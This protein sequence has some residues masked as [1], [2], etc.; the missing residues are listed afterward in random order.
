MNNKNPF[1]IDG[2]TILVTG[3]SSGIGRTI[4][5]E[6][7]SLGANVVITGRNEQRL[8]ETLVLLKGDGHSLIVANLLD[9]LDIDLIVSKL[10]VLDGIVNCA[11]L[12][13]LSPFTFVT[14]EVLSDVFEINFFAPVELIRLLIKKKRF[15][16]NASIVF[17]SSISGV[18]CSAI[19]SSAYSAS[20]GAI[21]GV[22]KGMALDLAS[23]GIRVNCVNPGVINTDF[24]ENTGVTAEDLENDIKRYPLGR[25]GCTEDVAYAAIYL[26]SDASSWVTGTNLLI[27]G[28]YTLL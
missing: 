24:F 26:L 16:K 5:I 18:Y 22:V 2:K 21:N 14:R 6:C 20:K 13:R 10:S 1:S 27:D 12:T 25:Y 8:N 23:K 4:A 15:S 11:G 28:G 7:A 17:L 19:A 9:S 3:A